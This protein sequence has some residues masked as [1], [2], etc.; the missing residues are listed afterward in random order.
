MVITE[1]IEER[2]R[3]RVQTDG[4][5]SDDGCPHENVEIYGNP[6]PMH[7]RVHGRVPTDLTA[8]AR[9][10]D[11]DTKLKVQWSFKQLRGPGDA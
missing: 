6:D 10:T 11:C 9:C 4:G 7:N 8:D 3:R 2:K 5:E 1:T